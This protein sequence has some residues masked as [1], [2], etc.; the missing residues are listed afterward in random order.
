MAFYLLGD[1][2]FDKLDNEDVTGIV[3]EAAQ[4]NR[5]SDIH[6][7]SAICT[8][9]L[10][11]ESLIRKSMDNVTIVMIALSGFRHALFP[12]TKE[13]TNAKEN[14][15]V[16]ETSNASKIISQYNRQSTGSDRYQSVLEDSARTKEQKSIH[17]FKVGQRLQLE[18][19]KGRF[20]LSNY[21]NGSATTKEQRRVVSSWA[22][23]RERVP[24][25]N[26][27]NN[28]LNITTKTDT[29]KT[30]KR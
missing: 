12:K 5:A 28:G 18:P 20:D 13:T 29:F 26:H 8:E 22:K 17:N 10:M 1:G 30:F 3:W 4:K 19:E 25:N 2:I 6:K 14:S 7:Q 15:N 9:F 23:S 16:K 27:L 24:E 21:L 11:K